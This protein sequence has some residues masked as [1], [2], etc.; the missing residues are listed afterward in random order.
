MFAQARSR[1]TEKQPMLVNSSER[2]FISRQWL[3]KHIP[4]AMDMHATIE[5]LLEMVFFV[6]SVLRCY[7]QGPRLSLVS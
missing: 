7:K 6:W 4:V 3:G 2:T 1:K 5:V